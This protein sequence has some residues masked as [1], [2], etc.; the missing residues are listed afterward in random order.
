MFGVRIRVHPLFW[1]VAA[2]LGF[3][4]YAAGPG[5]N[6]GLLFL[7]VGCVFVSILWHEFGHVLMGRAFG[8]D[9]HIVLYGM[10]GLAIGSKD[11]KQARWQ[12]IAVSLAGP[13][14]QL[15]LFAALWGLVHPTWSPVPVPWRRNVAQVLGML[16]FINLY[17]PLLNLLPLWPLDGGQIAREVCEGLLGV[18]GVIASL[19]IS[20]VVSGLLALQ[21]LAASNGHPLLPDALGRYIGSDMFMAFFFIVFC[22]GSVQA[23]QAER[24]RRSRWDDDWPW[25]R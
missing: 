22:V 12:R 5:G 16:L 1:V 15:L 10:G 6:F 3:D 24:S 2:V 17:W 11:G 8:A 14:A 7:W 9:G 13:L 25:R 18:K 4:A 20:I 21:V 23:L 19:W